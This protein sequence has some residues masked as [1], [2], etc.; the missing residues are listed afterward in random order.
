LKIFDE[1]DSVHR[2]NY[3]YTHICFGTP[4]PSNITHSINMCQINPIPRSPKE[5]DNR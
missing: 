3:N 5:Q 1:S 4:E 2:Q